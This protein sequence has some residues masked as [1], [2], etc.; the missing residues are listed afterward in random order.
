M[1][2]ITF[3]RECYRF[4]NP[5]IVSVYNNKG[6]WYQRVSLNMADGFTQLQQIIKNHINK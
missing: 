5:Y 3:K 4:G 2:K 6:L 1:V